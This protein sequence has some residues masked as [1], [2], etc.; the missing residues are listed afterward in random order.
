VLALATEWLGHAATWS[1]AG[2]T[3]PGRALSGPLHAYLGPVG[4]VL[5]VLAVAASWGVWRGLDRLSSL[6]RR[7]RRA[8]TAVATAPVP[9]P[10]DAGRAPVELPGPLRLGV[11]LATVQLVLYLCQ[12][13]LEAHLVGRA[14]PGLHALTAHLGAPLAIHLAL[15]LVGT[16][17]AVEVLDHWQL[18]ATDYERAR[19][20]YCALVAHRRVARLVPG[21]RPTL[22]PPASRYGW[23]LLG[24]AP[25]LVAA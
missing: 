6:T 21:P 7:L 2:G 14:A 25:P 5:A 20:R 19:V 24:R 4:V 13:N 12:E 8:T 23:S 11:S 9:D 17:L 1:L 22:R 15:A 10:L 16:A 3:A 18:R